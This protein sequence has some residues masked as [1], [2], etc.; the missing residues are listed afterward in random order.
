MQEY[1]VDSDNPEFPFNVEDSAQLIWS[2][3]EEATA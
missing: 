1:L 3:F 2:K